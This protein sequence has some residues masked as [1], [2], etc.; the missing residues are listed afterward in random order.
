MKA[1]PFQIDVPQTVLDDLG[2]R[3]ARIR[4]PNEVDGA[5]WDY[6]TNLAYIK[7]LAD[8]WQNEYDWR[9]Q[10]AKLNT[11][12]HFKVDIEGVKIHFIHEQ[13][14]GPNP[15]PL[16]LTHG[17]PDSFYR[18]HK[19]IPMLTDPERFGGSAEDSFDVVVPSLPGYGFSDWPV[20]GSFGAEQIADLLAELM[21][22]LGYERFA[23]QGG[24][25]GGAIAEQLALRH[26]DALIGV[27]LTD[28][29]FAHLFS[30]S[31]DNVSEA[32]RT[33][34]EAADAWSMT[35]GSYATLQATKPQTLAYGLNDS[36]VGLAAWLV[37]KFYTWSDHG[38]DL[39]ASFSK[40]ELLTNIML[41]WVTQTIRSS[42]ALYSA[43]AGNWLEDAAADWDA[44]ESTDAPADTAN[45]RAWGESARV[46]VPTGFAVFP[47]DLTH[48]PRDYAERFF[49]VQHFTQMP[50]GGHFAALE[51][52]KLFVQDLREFFGGLR[53]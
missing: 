40:D 11:F 42:F 5:G 39:E 16:L 38:G 41:Y 49:N 32:E 22:E 2:K 43:G 30:L 46:Q 19:V 36:P 52:P 24:D 8:Y 15:T 47:K 51:E 6:G 4:W 26:A 53:Q 13:G 37:E 45:G 35:E 21:R 48:P 23:V 27:H 10:E 18:F 25:W 28:V 50:R 1:Q 20:Q 17:W 44:D 34:L 33:F 29:P 7:E 3:L 12:K 14:K 9:K 31:R